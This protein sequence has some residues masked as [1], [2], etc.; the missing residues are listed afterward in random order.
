MND[1]GAANK[2]QRQMQVPE[3]MERTGQAINRLIDSISMLEEKMVKVLRNEPSAGTATG[4]DVV[5]LVILAS[6]L[7]S[8]ASE[9]NTQNNRVQSMIDRLEL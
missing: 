9:I 5:A 8:N 4:E 3:N 6:E 2:P 7:R 1:A